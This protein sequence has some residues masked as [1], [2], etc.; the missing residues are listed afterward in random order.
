M[1]QTL[2]GTGSLLI[3]DADHMC[4]YNLD[5]IE[6]ATT[7]SADGFVVSTP[8]TLWAAFTSSGCKLRLSDGRTIGVVVTK[9]SPGNGDAHVKS[10][11]GFSDT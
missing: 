7:R 9:Y 2:S 4:Q 1:N 5:I 3:K 6:T 11:G 10:D 8:E